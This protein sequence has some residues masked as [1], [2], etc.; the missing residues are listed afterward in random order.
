MTINKMKIDIFQLLKRILGPVF[1]EI[2]VFALNIFLLY[3]IIIE[4]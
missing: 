2:P 4:L 3:F 1:W